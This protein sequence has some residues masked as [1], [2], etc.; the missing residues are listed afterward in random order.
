MDHTRHKDVCLK[1]RFFKHAK[2]QPILTEDAK[3]YIAK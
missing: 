1:I 2:K 3:M